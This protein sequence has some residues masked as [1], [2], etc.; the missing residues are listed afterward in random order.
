MET[1]GVGEKTAFRNPGA[2]WI[3]CA[4]NVIIKQ[5]TEE[6]EANFIFILNSF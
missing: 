2:A 1:G 3:S 5:I 4:L 6:R